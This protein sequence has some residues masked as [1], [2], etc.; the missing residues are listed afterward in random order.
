[1][2]KLLAIALASLMVLG[3]IT[4]VKAAKEDSA[5]LEELMIFT[6]KIF[7]IANDFDDISTSVKDD[8]YSIVWAYKDEKKI[9]T[10]PGPIRQKGKS[11]RLL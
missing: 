1:M 8:S 6:K 5:K 4:P 2:K 11:H 9:R 7:S 3:L 10:S